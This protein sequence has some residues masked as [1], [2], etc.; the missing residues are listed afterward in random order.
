MSIQCLIYFF[1]LVVILLDFGADIFLF[2]KLF[3]F[4]QKAK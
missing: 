1:I 4:Q 3:K 2:Y